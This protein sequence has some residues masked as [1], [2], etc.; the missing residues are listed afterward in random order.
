MYPVRY[1]GVE[2]T[3][4]LTSHEQADL[5]KKYPYLKVKEIVRAG[6]R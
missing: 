3:V 1:E 2:E 5:I 6:W 4:D